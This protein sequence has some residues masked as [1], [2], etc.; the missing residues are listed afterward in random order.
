MAETEERSL[1]NFF[2]KR[3]KKKKKERSSRAANAAS[4][5]GGSSAAAGS[6]PGDGGSLGS[7]ARSGDGGSSGSGARSGDGGSLGSGARSGDGGTSRSGDGGSAGPGGKAITK[8]ENEWKEFEQKEVDYS[9]L[10]VQAMQISE[11]EDDDNEKREDP[12]DN[13]EE[14]G[15]GSGAEKSS[16]PWNKTALV[17]APPAPVTVTET[18]EPAMPSGVYRPPGARLTTTRKTPQGPPEIYSDT[19]F[20]SLQSTAKHVESRNRYLK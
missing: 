1:D 17:Q 13:W 6:R 12:G 4:G 10:R 14:G 8:D 15:G 9:G 3:D 7:G 20:P 11:K 16:G 18:P 5:A 19:Q 2:A